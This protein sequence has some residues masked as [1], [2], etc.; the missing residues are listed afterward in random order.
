MSRSL[1]IRRSFA[2]SRVK[3]VSVSFSSVPKFY[4]YWQQASTSLTMLS[5]LTGSVWVPNSLNSG[6]SSFFVSSKAFYRSSSLDFTI[7][8]IS[9]SNVWFFFSRASI[10]PCISKM[11]SSYLLFRLCNS[12]NS[13]P[14][15]PFYSI[16][17]LFSAFKAYIS[18]KCSSL[19][20]S[21]ISFTYA[22]LRSE[23]LALIYFLTSL[24][25]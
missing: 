17:S 8:S 24:I 3:F 16:K 14:S 23:Y 4:S 22:S 2:Y 1:V 15:L 7:C 10:L 12:L 6:A 13:R 11:K 5:T 20:F 25:Y 19:T 21:Q 9:S 18:L